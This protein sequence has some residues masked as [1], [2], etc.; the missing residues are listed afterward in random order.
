[1]PQE[2]RVYLAALDSALHIGNL[3]SLRIEDDMA[4]M[5][6]CTGI[7]EIKHMAASGFDLKVHLLPE[8]ATG[9]FHL[10][11]RPQSPYKGRFLKKCD[12]TVRCGKLMS[13]INIYLPEVPPCLAIQNYTN[14]STRL[15]CVFPRSASRRLWA[16]RCGV[17]AWSLPARAV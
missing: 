9:Q 17:L 14:G 12:E 3:M 7:L 13:V 8:M 11:Y 1:M 16:W 6:Y 5:S 2:K 4:K 10:S 15:S